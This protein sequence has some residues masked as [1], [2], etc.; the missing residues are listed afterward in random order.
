MY[1]EVKYSTEVLAECLEEMKPLLE[2]HWEEIALHRDKIELN[3]D[4]NKYYEIEATGSLH[5]V[6]ARK[7]GKLVGYFISFVYP[8]VH[9]KDHYFAINDILFV[10]PSCRNSNVGKDMFKYAESELGKEGVSVIMIA[11]KTHAPFDPLCEAL[12]YK[13]VER[14]YS[15]YIGD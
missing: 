14:V 2:K 15:K 13:N 8:H 6:T 12:G 10:S 1:D 4:Y 9:Y 7:G 11:M 5:I 3:P